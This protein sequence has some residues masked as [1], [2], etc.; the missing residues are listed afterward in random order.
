M[1]ERLAYRYA[2]QR[3]PRGACLCDLDSSE[4]YAA[5]HWEAV[6]L[7]PKQWW[8]MQCPKCPGVAECETIDNGVGNLQVS[9]FH[10]SDCGWIEGDGAKSAVVIRVLAR[11]ARRRNA[12]LEAPEEFPDNA[13]DSF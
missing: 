6:P 13:L 1:T 7:D 4:C 11:H 5:G 8:R 10:C 12:G 2:L 9:A 3:R